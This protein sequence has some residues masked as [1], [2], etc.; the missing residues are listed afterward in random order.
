MLA[1][2]QA[3][4]YFG[5]KTLAVH[6]PF[7]KLK[8]APLPAVVHWE[9]NHFIVVYKISK[10]W[11][12]V[13]DPAF[14]LHKYKIYEFLQGWVEKSEQ[15]GVALLLDPSK[16]FFESNLKVTNENSLLDF[17]K[18]YLLKYKK[19]FSMII[20]T[21]FFILLI[22]LIFPFLTQSIVDVGIAN[23]NL[24]FIH[25]ILAAQLMLYLSQY[26]IEFI[27]TWLLL[28]ISTRINIS[29]ISDFLAKLLKLPISFFA[30]KS[31]GDLIQRVSD[32]QRIEN[33]FSV[34]TFNMIFS[35]LSILI[36]GIVLFYYSVNIFIVFM[37]GSFLSLAW[38]LMFVKKR[39]YIDYKKFNQMSENQN[40]LYQIIFGMQELKLNNAENDKR[41]EW[42]KTQ[43]NLF[44]LSKS[45]LTL[46]QYQ[47]GGSFIINQ[48][49]NL[50]LT[51]LTAQQVIEGNLSL[52]SLLAISYILGQLNAPLDQLI[53][54]VNMIQDGKLSF[55]RLSEINNLRNEDSSDTDSISRAE[56]KNINHED[57]IIKNLF[58]K[59]N[60]NDENFVL[61]NI[62]FKIPSGKITAIVGESGSG[63]STLLK[64]LLKFYNPTSGDICLGSENLK[65]I[66]HSIWRRQCG[67]VLQEG[68]IFGDT[69]EKNIS[70][71]HEFIDKNKINLS[72]EI[73]NCTE[74]TKYLPK[75]I[76]TKIGQNG[77]E[78]SSGQKQ[79]ILIARAIYKN[80]N[81]IFF[82]EATSDL[83]TLNETIITNNLKSFFK[84]KTVII[85]AHRLSTIKNADQIVVLDHNKII[86]IGTHSELIE[87][88]GKYFELIQNQL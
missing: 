8:D 14:G 37:I 81:F 21:F 1:L 38:I 75:G 5:F 76:K 29:L 20:L 46:S 63:K 52:G 79:R 57:I 48:I 64:L 28:H 87:T 51:V 70:L 23:K 49:K 85:I 7:E 17:I 42:E 41:W 78:L 13:S 88:K 6:I 61:N 4:E 68:F 50:V 11:V 39:G 30:T 45:S 24:Q 19:Q 10:N 66:S 55:G 60:K 34:T 26:A 44:G 80:P 54:F 53:I 22:N 59:Y 65:D 12:F 47:Q 2:S 56:H 67:V 18:H 77:Q 74:F 3:A 69:I 35:F 86:E 15:K 72:L 84:N 16:Q 73:S 62:N 27:R 33:F 71:K 9:E 58:F 83:D 82:D 31:I 36:Y 25:I 40:K 43:M 32:H